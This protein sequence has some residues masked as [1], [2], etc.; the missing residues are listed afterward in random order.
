MFGSTRMSL[1]LMALAA[2]A[3]AIP[4]M[5]AAPADLVTGQEAGDA[6]ALLN[7]SSV[8]SQISGPGEAA[9]KLQCGVTSAE[10][11]A[12][13]RAS[14]G[15][16]AGVDGLVNNRGTDS[17]PNVTQSETSVAINGNIVLVGYNDSGQF[18]PT[19]DFTGYARST[20]GGTTFTDMGT[21]PTPGDNIQAV[22][23]DP[24]IV[25]DR[26]RL[27]GD[28]GRFYFANLATLTS[29]SGRSVISVHRSTDGGQ[30]WTGANASPLAPAGAFQ[31]K[32]WMA[33]DTRPGGGNI[34]VC[35]R[36]FGGT[37]GI[38]FSRSVDNGATFTQLAASL[39]A[40]PLT[41]QGCQVA[42]GPT[43]NVH[44]FWTDFSGPTVRVRTSTDG[45]VTFGPAVAVG[46]VAFAETVISCGGQNRTVF[47]DA[48][49]G[50][51]GRA[52]RSTLFSSVALNPNN[53][54]ILVAVHRAGLPGG[55]GAD[56]AV[57]RSTDGGATWSAPVLANSVVTGH[58]F[59][60][61]IAYNTL[62]EA[63]LIY[64]STQNSATNRLIDVYQVTS[65]NDGVA[66]G[67]P[68][69]ITDVSFDRPQTNPNFDTIVAACYMG[70]YNSIAAAAPG[71]GNADFHMAW[72]DN[73]LD[74]NPNVAGVQPD[75]DIFY[76]RDLA[77]ETCRVDF[78][79]ESGATR[80]FR[81]EDR[82]GCANWGLNSW[83][84]WSAADSGKLASKSVSFNP[85][86]QPRLTSA[87]V[88]LR[89]ASRLVSVVAFNSGTSA[90]TVTLACEGQP[91]VSQSVAAGAVMTLTTGW[92]GFCY[93]LTVTSSNGAATNFDDFLFERPP[94]G[95]K[96]QE[97]S[98]NDKATGNLNGQY[99]TG[100]LDWGSGIWR[101]AGPYGAFTTRSA[102]YRTAG[103]T[104]G[105]VSFVGGAGLLESLQ[106]HNG[107]GG[108][109]TL[110]LKCAGNA[111]AVVSLAAGATQTIATGFT[112]PCTSVT[113]NNSSGW[114][115]NLDNLLITKP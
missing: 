101:V 12:V 51:N 108:A 11:G 95:A 96:Q 44:V 40:T 14:I 80:E 16:T 21:L 87:T 2:I 15:V 35:W 91:T 90:T 56:I 32:E 102:S 93:N 75:P 53:G 81:G 19:G 72:G 88:H 23:G 41:G 105:G 100:V 29:P 46:A 18:G 22:F 7:D 104:S 27:G 107:G 79:G 3:V 103:I 49:A 8:M 67:A 9:L 10:S 1:W 31:D 97:V 84:L 68:V 85:N 36:Q 60:A 69:R 33:V 78:N 39:D 24:V 86:K 71:L 38:Q 30:T 114:D 89:R 65:T 63:R 54:T 83:Y 61:S 59:F 111:D 48:E 92:T 34:Y 5:L 82:T 113:V 112:T 115:T 4:A 73:R 55:N 77:L 50:A 66:W 6:C 52:I 98:F 42:V 70:D 94:L 47:V 20:N 110:T 43:G 99:P 64:Y 37:N 62:G 28:N 109:T 13:S 57:F 17:F 45:G 106:A 74:A 76:D 25:A 26:N 58:Q